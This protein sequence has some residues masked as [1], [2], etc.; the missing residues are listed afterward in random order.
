MKLSQ[1]DHNSHDVY[2][3]VRRQLDEPSQGKEVMVYA[4][5]VYAALKHDLHAEEGLGHYARDQLDEQGGLRS[6]LSRL[7]LLDS[8]PDK[9][10][11]EGKSGSRGQSSPQP[12]SA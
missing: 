9:Q 3:L 4:V 10:L 8:G 2:E 1:G 6:A 7:D 5:M 11:A 12:Q